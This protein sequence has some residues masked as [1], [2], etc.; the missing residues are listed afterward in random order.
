MGLIAAIITAII[1]IVVYVRMYKRELPEAAGVKR[2]IIPVALGVLAVILVSPVTIF[3]SLS[4]RKLLGA[5][6]K[7]VLPSPILS[8]L[9]RAFL[10]AGFTEEL[11]KF[12]MFL[13]TIKIVK[14]R[15]VY[16]Y[17]M[18]C[19]GIGVGFTVLEDIFYG[20]TNPI[21]WDSPNTA[22]ERV[23]MM[24]GS[25]SSLPF[26]CRSCGTPYSTQ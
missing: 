9:V 19:A 24:P 20:A 14:P 4:T 11:V 6:I 15:N 16:E 5:S 10:L 12:L 18:F 8:S 22:R 25:I 26:S 1:C 3:I 21:T 23:L 7:E 2:A 17:G 13:I